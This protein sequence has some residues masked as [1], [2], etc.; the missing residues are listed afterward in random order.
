[1]FPGGAVHREDAAAAM[2]ARCRGLDRLDPVLA[3]AAV[4]AIRETF[5][6]CGVLLA[7]RAGGAPIDGAAHRGLVERYQTAVAA[8]KDAWLEMIAAE[9]L[10][11]ACDRLVPFAH[12]I[13]PAGRPK[14]FDARFFVA[15]AP[16]GQVAAHDRREAVDAVWLRPGDAVAGADDG[17]F[18]IVFATRMNLIKLAM[19]ATVADALAAARAA[20]IVTVTPRLEQRPDGAFMCIPLSAGYGVEAVPAENIPRA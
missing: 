13:T 20:P 11:L 5:E 17:R 1:V 7:E 14:R 2:R 18:R 16:D 8:H 3:E 12:W 19:S 6:E 10:E 9:A 4:A 15:P